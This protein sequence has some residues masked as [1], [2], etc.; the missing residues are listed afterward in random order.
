MTPHVRRVLAAA[1]CA[2]AA[3][4]LTA[5]SSAGGT[6]TAGTA[7]PAAA[8]SSPTA[9]ADPDAGL[10]DG[11]K[12]TGWLLPASAVPTLKADS[13][14][15]ENSADTYVKPTDTTIP[16]AKACDQLGATNWMEAGGIGPSS[17][18][19]D[20][21]ADEYG[22]EYYQQLNAYRTTRAAQEFAALTKVFAECKAFPAKV[23][24]NSYTMHLKTRTLTGLGDE[25]V[26]AVMSSPDIQG[27]TTLV[28][29][30]SGKILVTT[31]YD[32]QNGSGA[33]ALTLA[34][35]LLK[36]VPAAPADAG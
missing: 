27:G 21:F 31:M 23:A 20:D 3:L 7:A 13:Q 8:T 6:A 34:R 32:D 28:V 26:E 4:A 33:K 12:M 17:T 19:G 1:L 36:N 25:A 15:A 18:A 9:T 35:R 14:A 24:G 22:N 10:P 11:T 29:I 5:C 30:R 16:R 2:G